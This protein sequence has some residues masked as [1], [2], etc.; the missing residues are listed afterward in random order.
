MYGGAE[1]HL[2]ELLVRLNL[3]QVEPIVVC[4]GRDVY[5]KV[6]NEQ[7][8]LGIR[9]ETLREADRMWSCWLLFVRLRP[10]VVV[11]VNGQLGLFAWSAYLAARL[12][13]A[14]RV[15]AIEH[16]VA[17]PP[18]GRNGGLGLKGWVRE[19]VGWRARH[20]ARLRAAGSLSH[21]TICV[22][23][24]VRERL[25]T[26]YGYSSDRTVTVLNGV[27]VE[28][29]R[30]EMRD[31]GV[32]H[33]EFGLS[34]GE[35]VVV[36]VASLVHQKRIDLLLEALSRLAA[37]RVPCQCLI[38]GDGPL[39]AG[40]VAMAAELGLASSVLFV[41]H[42]E[43]IRSCLAAAD[44]F[45]LSSA[46]EGLPLALLEAMACGVPCIATNVGGNNE[47][48]SHGEHG[49]IVQAG[50]CEALTR[51]LRY[52]LSH[53]DEMQVMARNGKARVRGCFRIE[54]TMSRVTA[55]L[56]D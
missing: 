48:I 34:R 8:R 16:L 30:G 49:L 33:K 28:H 2:T 17:D 36:C 54:D 10:A 56:V 3:S 39:R 11:F 27:D 4:A 19:K 25:V 18:P 46:K 40:L 41:G 29:Y 31:S 1:R 24:A 42:V 21:R 55:I 9:V 38:L 14:H 52:A 13:W 43:D 23:D 53:R 15:I 51:A 12:A 22:S 47:V 35:P 26:E 44:L 6:L 20:M 37:E 32:I 5:S 45:V 50:S 7:R